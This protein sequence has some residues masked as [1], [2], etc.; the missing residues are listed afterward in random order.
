MT[1]I[2]L[3]SKD[4][5]IRGILALQLAN[6]PENLSE[7]QIQ[8][9]GFV[10]VVHTF[11]VLKQMNETAPSVIA[12]DGNDI[13]GYCIV[14][15]PA[16]SGDIPELAPMFDVFKRMAYKGKTIPEYDYV[17]TGQVCVAEAYRGRQVFDRMYQKYREAYSDRYE[18][19][20]TEIATRNT[21]SLRA[22]ERVGFDVAL[23]YEAP[24]GESWEVV[25]WDWRQ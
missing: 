1:T 15:T 5:E 3:L 13:A 20:I 21:R 4:E 7:I 24:D 14:M 22:H 8:R 19:L 2:Q 11:D 17:L 23:Q 25:V 10:T 6:R 18:L 16:A 9:Q 12:K